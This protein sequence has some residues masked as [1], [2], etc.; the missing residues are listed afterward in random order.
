MVT[1]DA[2]NI[3]LDERIKLK[4]FPFGLYTMGAVLNYS[5]CFNLENELI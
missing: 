3:Y 5:Q 1:C 2:V 4:I